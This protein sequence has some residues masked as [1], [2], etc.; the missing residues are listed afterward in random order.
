[1]KIQGNVHAPIGTKKSLTDGN[2]V[3]GNERNEPAAAA[4]QNDKKDAGGQKGTAAP[5]AYRVSVSKEGRELAAL[6][7]K[8]PQNGGTAEKN[9]AAPQSA[10]QRDMSA[11]EPLKP[12]RAEDLDWATE[13][14]RASLAETMRDI[15]SGIG[16]VLR[17]ASENPFAVGADIQMY[18]VRQ[19]NAYGHHQKALG[20]SLKDDPYLNSVLDRLGALDPK[21]ENPLLNEIRTLVGMTMSGKEI[22]LFED[23]ERSDLVRRYCAYL[24][25]RMD[26]ALTDEDKKGEVSNEKTET[27]TVFHEMSRKAK[28]MEELID[29][30]FGDDRAG[31]K[32]DKKREKPSDLSQILAEKRAEL[33]DDAKAYKESLRALERIDEDADEGEAGKISEEE[34]GQAKKRLRPRITSYDWNRILEQYLK[35]NPELAAMLSMKPQEVKP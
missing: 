6:H 1:M 22:D 18:L 19:L 5:P 35:E 28:R 32:E 15:E 12:M 10:E 34:K 7:T 21:S 8:A 23:D 30:M 4:L 26:D 31:T 20:H 13:Y 24:G 29:D 3:L 33:D 14:E 2:R 17:G 11:A 16:A 9:N 25:I 27:Y